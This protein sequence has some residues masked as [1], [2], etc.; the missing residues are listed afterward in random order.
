MPRM[1]MS[2]E[3]S[4]EAAAAAESGVPPEDLEYGAPGQTIPVNIMKAGADPVTL[5]KS[6]YPEW[7]F[8]LTKPEETEKELLQR[9]DEVTWKSGGAKYFRRKNRQRIKDNN[10]R[11]DAL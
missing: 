6:E 2:T 10:M 11:G 4:A 5:P 7:L 1:M 9:K 3:A 8:E